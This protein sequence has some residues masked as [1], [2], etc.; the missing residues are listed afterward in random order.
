MNAYSLPCSGASCNAADNNGNLRKQT[1]YIPNNDQNTNPTSWYQQYDY[2][3]LNRLQRAH[4]YTGNTQLDWQQEYFYDRWGNRTIHQTNTWG[5][6][7]PKPNFGVDP[8]NKNRLTAP[9]GYTMSYD[10]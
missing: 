5:T 6:G 2:D 10:N 3:N 7:I 1:T 8:N 4:E 9:A